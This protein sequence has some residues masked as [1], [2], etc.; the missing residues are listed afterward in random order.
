MVRIV[1]LE[2]RDCAK[3]EYKVSLRATARTCLLIKA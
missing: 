3:V 1:E 2:L